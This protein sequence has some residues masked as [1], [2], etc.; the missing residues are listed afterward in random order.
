MRRTDRPHEPRRQSLRPSAGQIEPPSD[1]RTFHHPAASPVLDRVAQLAAAA[2]A[3][4]GRRCAARP[5]YP[6]PAGPAPGRG[7]RWCRRTGATTADTGLPLAAAGETA[8]AQVSRGHRAGGGEAHAQALAAG[9]VPLAEVGHR[10]HQRARGALCGDGARV[11]GRG[12]S[13][14]A[15]EGSAPVNFPVATALLAAS[16]PSGY[17]PHPLRWRPAGSSSGSR[18][19][20]SVSRAPPS[21]LTCSTAPF[22]LGSLSASTGWGRGT[23]G[24]TEGG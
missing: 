7:P 16:E 1:A 5:R 8:R 24:A 13:I 19:E 21:L 18:P 3:R 2:D 23:R 22:S 12:T 17:P 9:A 14:R 15:P 20:S 4:G 6:G 11:P 10:Q